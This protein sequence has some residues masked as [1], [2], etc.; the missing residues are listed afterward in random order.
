MYCLLYNFYSIEDELLRKR[1]MPE[2][3]DEDLK[4]SHRNSLTARRSFFKRRRH[5]RNSSKDSRDFI[6]SDISI[7]GDSVG[8]HEGTH[9]LA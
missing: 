8:I 5:Q 2:L 4:S 3:V 7:N 9:S 6:H 1:S